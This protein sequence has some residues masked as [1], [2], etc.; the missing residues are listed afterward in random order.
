MTAFRTVLCPIDFSDLTEP[1]VQLAGAVARRLGAR[2]V[3]HHNLSAGPPEFL[4]VR[5]MWSEEHRRDRGGDARRRSERL[6][7]AFE[8]VPE[9]VECEGRLTRGPLDLAV[10]QVAA[11][12]PADLIVMGSHG[13]SSAS[14]RSLA[15]R[16]V[17]AAPCPVLTV[18]KRCD[19]AHLLEP[20]EPRPAD[21]LSFLVPVDFSPDSMAVVSF[22]AHLMET[23][24]HRLHLLHVVPPSP[25]LDDPRVR[26]A[27]LAE[28]RERLGGL[29]PTGAGERTVLEVRE[30]TPAD[31]IVSVADAGG[32][33]FILM[34]AARPGLLRRVLFGDT[35]LGVLHGARCPV[36][37]L[38]PSVT[39]RGL[40]RQAL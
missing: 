22:A 19:L 29:V 31:E 5:W 14:H 39:Y 24:P 21:A 17:V 8:S 1:T 36:W 33:L 28:R 25:A 38:P 4:S 32:A 2:L 18:G 34:P 27:T 37:F 13:W 23:M 7:E 30:G 35:T 15:E 10:V 20:V 16:M 40:E 3:L 6:A 12:L 9:G 26:H 11:Q